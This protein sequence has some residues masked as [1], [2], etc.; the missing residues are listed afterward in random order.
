MRNLKKKTEVFLSVLLLSVCAVFT[1]TVHA[2]SEE[3]E[4]ESNV[5]DFSAYSQESG[6]AEQTPEAAEGMAL[7]EYWSADSEAAES[8]RNYVSRVTNAEDEA[9]FIPE[10]DRIAVFDMD[11]TLTCETFFTYYDTMMFIDYCNTALESN[12]WLSEKDK[13]ELKQVAASITPDYKAGEELARNFARAYS[14]MTVQE[15]YDYAVEFG[16][17][18]AARFNNMRF[19]DG[20]YLPMVELVKYL[21]ENDF[22]VY[23]ISGTERTT[24]RAIVANSPISEYVTPNHVIGTDFEVKVAGHEKTSSNMDFKYGE[25]GN[26]DALVI[27]GGFIQKN[28]NANKT[29]YIE[30]EIGQRPVLAFGNSGSDTSMMNYAIIG[31]EYP[32]E[33]YMIVADDS[34]REWGTQDWAEKSEAYAAQGY[35]PVSMKND[36]ARIYPREISKEGADKAAFFPSWDPDSAS[37]NELIAFVSECT[38]ETGSGYLDPADRIAVFDMD[39]TILCEKAPI[40]FDYCLTMYRVLDDPAYEA[41][42]EERNA[43]QQIRDRAY[44]EGVVFN[45]EGLGKDELVATAFAGMTPEAFRAYV[46]NFADSVNAVGFEGMTYGQSFYRPMLEVI[47]FL[48]AN[49]FDVWMV[50]ACERE[51]VRA[52]TERIDI[53][54]DHVIGT[55]VPYVAAGKG[56]AEADEYDMGR[57][58]EIL[59]GAPL[60]PVETGKSGKPVAI[61][62]E[63]GRRPV[64]AFGNSSGDF[65]MLNFAEGNPKHE[66]MGF[67]V[68]CDDTEREYGSAE[69]AAGFYAEAE[70]EG[71]TPI[72]MA[73][74][75][76][77]IYNEN[78][79][80]TGL[81]GAGET[82]EENTEAVETQEAETQAEE[83][84]AEETQANAA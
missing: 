47:D 77:I 43:M 54:F 73:N 83:T 28:L 69:K 72:S 59:L 10:E 71:W 36:F 14:G 49:D 79:R 1:G 11:G 57:D 35:V 13:E 42:E 67:F 63:I 25:G 20:F 65:S 9:N 66:G 16:K 21:Y 38:D 81:P 18:E 62:R 22:T 12:E 23:V 48:R 2:E 52:L 24:T 27:T 3:S 80:K 4:T 46:T 34:V 33:A 8:L 58:E 60:D 44:S 53:P 61:I 31:N 29:I 7:T 40:Y 78:V 55:D 70:K 37:L 75:W 51:V 32:A 17:K 41:T 45:P 30:R 5:I 68:V 19:I 6:A 76:E 84:Q 56:E 39:G 74:D 82:I 15:L 26:D 64:L 50:S